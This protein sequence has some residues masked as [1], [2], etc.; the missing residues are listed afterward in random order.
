M[1]PIREAI[2]RI[3]SAVHDE[4]Q[5]INYSDTEILDAIN[6]GL[7][8]IRRTIAEIQPEILMTT[9][10]GTL[11]ATQS[12]IELPSRPLQI[13]D[14]TAGKYK[15]LE[16]NLQHV[17]K[18]VASEH[19]KYFY[20]VGLQSLKVYPKP[21]VETEYAVRYVEDIGELG[22]EDTTPILNEFDD[23]LIEYAAYRLALTD[24]FD[25][26]Q[27]QQ[28]IANIHQQIASILAPPPA[29]TVVRG[30]W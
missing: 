29:G 16:T 13:I 2:R 20:R 14:L 26:T 19:P 6:S 7:R 12:E 5:R 8:V 4:E 11:A 25:M 1:L 3:R 17:R 30:Y 9:E 10:M 23:F 15:L 28:I 27:E 21:L 22:I 18:K 24:E